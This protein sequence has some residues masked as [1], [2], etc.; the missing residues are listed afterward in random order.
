MTV[1]KYPKSWLA[2]RFKLI[3]TSS[4]KT[5]LSILSGETSL[6]RLGGGV[7][8]LDISV[9]ME[10]IDFLQLKIKQKLCENTI[11]TPK[12][13]CDGY[14]LCSTFIAI[15]RNVV[16]SM[17]WTRPICPGYGDRDNN[18]RIILELDLSQGGG[19]GP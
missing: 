2:V 11:L 7:L 1:L 18:Q 15:C 17:F 10:I 8:L 4:G 6:G 19:R 9:K 14:L 3:D 13:M 5:H 16:C 12:T